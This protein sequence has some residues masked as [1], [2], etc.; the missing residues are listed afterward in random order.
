MLYAHVGASEVPSTSASALT[1]KSHVVAYSRCVTLTMS[2]ELSQVTRDTFAT[3]GSSRVARIIG[4]LRVREIRHDPVQFL[5][6]LQ[7][8]SVECDLS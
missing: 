1:P 7:L 2:C 3:V 6:D 4:S 8:R 5:F